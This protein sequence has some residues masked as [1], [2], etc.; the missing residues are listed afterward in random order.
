MAQVEI[1]KSEN[2]GRPA[3]RDVGCVSDDATRRWSGLAQHLAA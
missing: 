3:R 1:S 2:A